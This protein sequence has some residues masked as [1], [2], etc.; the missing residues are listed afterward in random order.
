MSAFV[1]RV[2]V[3]LLLVGIALLARALSDVLLIVFTAVLIAVVLRALAAPLLHY[4]AL[5]QSICVLIALGLLIGVLGVGGWL[6]GRRIEGDLAR[7]VSEFPNGIAAL[8]ARFQQGVI[9]GS[10]VEALRRVNGGNLIWRIVALGPSLANIL[11]DA[12]VAIFS[13]VFLALGPAEYR[14]GVVK[15]FPLGFAGRIG[16]ALDNAGRALKLWLTGQLIAMVTIGVLTGVGLA[17]AGIPAA[18]ALGMV[19]GLLEFVPF[20]GPI[21][22]A[23]PGLA[24]AALQGFDTMLLA[25]AV[26]VGV[27][28]V[29]ANVVM[30]FVQKWAVSAPPALTLLGVVTM[31]ALFGLPGVLL[32]APLVIVLLV[33]VQQLYVRDVLGHDVVIAGQ[34]RLKSE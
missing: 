18:L 5:P 27:H 28:L 15:L 25:L 21:M 12:L 16:S 3:A 32:S 10:V 19:A 14:N 17:L 20:V 31:G 22:S 11:S 33:L 24:L 23:V 2:V 7:L 6:F 13:G 26:Y 34:D 8:Q 29:E 1:L 4:T 9:G 30:P